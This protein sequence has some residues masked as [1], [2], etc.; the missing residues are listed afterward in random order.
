MTS[1]N[2]VKLKASPCA[3][4][5][6]EIWHTRLTYRHNQ[7]TCQIYSQSV[8]GLRSSDTP[9]IAISHLLAVSPLQQCTHRRATLTNSYSFHNTAIYWWIT[10]NPNISRL[11]LTSCLGIVA[12][13]L[14][15]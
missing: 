4:Q 11:Y 14:T 9:K 3:A 2:P 6:Y 15:Q 1:G 10:A 12:Q 7:I 13:E 8:Q 5:F